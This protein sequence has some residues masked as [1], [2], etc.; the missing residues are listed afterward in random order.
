MLDQY[1]VH[2]RTVKAGDRPFPWMWFVAPDEGRDG[3]DE[4]GG[5]GRVLSVCR[6]ADVF[7][8]GGLADGQETEIPALDVDV[9]N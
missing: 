4:N 9:F 5:V 6:G 8:D 7:V 2:V 1:P 3:S